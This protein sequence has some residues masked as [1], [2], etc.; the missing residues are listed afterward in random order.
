MDGHGRCLSFFLL[1]AMEAFPRHV[2][3]QLFNQHVQQVTTRKVENHENLS[4]CN[5][6]PPNMT[7]TDTQ[8]SAEDDI[9]RVADFLFGSNCLD[10]A[11]NI[12][13]HSNPSVITKVV[14]LQ[15]SRVLF[16]VGGHSYKRSA[17]GRRRSN[18]VRTDDDESCHL[19]ILPEDSLMEARS[20]M[21]SRY[22]AYCSCRAFME[23]SN[24]TSKQSHCSN[25]P[26]QEL[27]NNLH[28]STSRV[29][30]E[31]C[32]SLEL[33]TEGMCE[34]LLSIMLATALRLDHI[35]VQELSTELEFSHLVLDKIWPC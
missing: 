6:G 15:S 23:H 27:Y 1:S 7:R 25:L 3:I 33:S 20:A 21:H 19:C 28:P 4:S 2:P 35:Q 9:L 31:S 12:L 30:Q 5:A 13:L 17:G 32:S 8:T 18:V 10:G 11:M 14:S 29:G 22:S 26:Q 16:L 34:H 24:R